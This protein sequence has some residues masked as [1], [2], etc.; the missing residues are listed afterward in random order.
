MFC[1]NWTDC[2][3]WTACAT[4]CCR[5]ISLWM[6]MMRCSGRLTTMCWPHTVALPF[7]Y[8]GNSITTSY[9]TTATMQQP[10]GIDWF[11]D[12]LGSLSRGYH[13]VVPRPIAAGPLCSAF[14]SALISRGTPRQAT[15]ETSISE[16]QNYGRETAG[17]FGL[18]LPRKSQGSF[19]YRRSA[20]WDRQLYF[21]SEG[22]H[23]VDF[24][25]RKIRQFRPGLN[26]RSCVPEASML[27]T[28]PPK[29][30]WW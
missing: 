30:L 15:W 29:P 5:S 16:G 23:A 19:T 28:R 14:S 24:F 9:Q 7:T 12:W 26:P 25:A 18:R 20:S 6:T 4:S 21:P 17:Q 10:T 8:S 2:C 22:R 13:P 3:K 27:N 11:I 1:R